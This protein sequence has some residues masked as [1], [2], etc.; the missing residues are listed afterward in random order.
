MSCKRLWNSEMH[1]LEKKKHRARL[2]LSL[3]SVLALHVDGIL[4]RHALHPSSGF[5]L[6][7][8][9]TEGTAEIVFYRLLRPHQLC[10]RRTGRERER[11]RR[12]RIKATAREVI[13]DKRIENTFAKMCLMYPC[14]ARARFYWTLRLAHSRKKRRA[15][16]RYNI[17]MKYGKHA[18][19]MIRT[20]RTFFH[21]I[22]AGAA[23]LWANACYHC[24]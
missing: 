9:V 22:S 8:T 18:R 10:E 3:D 4:E 19:A 17:Y 11:E 16:L 6:Q 13:T 23:F 21:D 14:I 7:C 12:G 5:A 2:D 20:I 15:L 24:I 1:A